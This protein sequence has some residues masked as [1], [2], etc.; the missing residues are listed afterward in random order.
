MNKTL[1]VL[2]QESLVGHLIMHDDL[3]MSYRYTDSWL[4][5]KHAFAL[6]PALTL[7]K[8]S[9]DNRATRAFFENLLPE[10]E[11]LR[12]LERAYRQNFS[13][14]Y[15]FLERFG[16]DC[17]GAFIIT[18]N[19]NFQAECEPLEAEELD[20]AR[21]MQAIEAGEDA[22]I[23]TLTNYGGKFSLAGEQDKIPVVYRNKKLYIPTKGG[24]TT[25]IL[26]PP[27][28]I[29]SLAST[30]YNEL[31]CM[32]LAEAIG[33]EIPATTLIPGLV[34][35]YLV[36]RYDRRVS[37]TGVERLHQV[38]LCQALGEPL[39]LKY[40]E[41]GGAGIA[42]IYQSI[43]Q[44]SANAVKDLQK[45]LQWIAFNLLIGNNDSHSKN[46]SLLRVGNSYRLAPFYDLVST[47]IYKEFDPQFAYSIGGQRS[48]N[49]LRP[50]HFH[51]LAT[52]LGFEKHKDI[53]W[54]ELTDT[55]I[56]I[57]EALPNSLETFRSK[58]TN[59]PAIKKIAALVEKRI[60][61][62]GI[63]PSPETA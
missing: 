29:K 1:F 39:H 7:R 51:M 24:A 15:S 3:T 22:L 9:F 25:H 32:Q 47:A 42:E 40:Q 46:I 2:Y 11:V 12:A 34:P 17:A 63:T 36:E 4:T 35:L 56:R 37:A 20:V 13:D 53:V 6:S 38:D 28:R 27:V 21:L 45:F 59:P 10:G 5:N 19:E 41:H 31:F 49:K 62:L 14:N 23:H 33:L 16:I 52:T 43:K 48:W 58:Y 55:A 61:H 60:A 57:K 30:V 8:D 18:T 26:K 50:K 54:T 44:L